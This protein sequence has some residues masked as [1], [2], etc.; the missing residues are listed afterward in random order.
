MEDTEKYKEKSSYPESHHLEANFG[1]FLYRK[2]SIIKNFTW[3]FFE[4]LVCKLVN[5][6]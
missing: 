4:S 6:S 5:Q 2:D 1:K 3:I